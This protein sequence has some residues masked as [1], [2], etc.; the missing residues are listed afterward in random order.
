MQ[1]RMLEL[2]LRGGYRMWWSTITPII[3]GHLSVFSVPEF[4]RVI[5][6]PWHPAEAM[7]GHWDL[8]SI[9]NLARPHPL[10]E[11]DQLTR[12][13]HIA[14][15][16][17]GVALISLQLDDDK[18]TGWLCVELFLSDTEPAQNGRSVCQ[19]WAHILRSSKDD[20]RQEAVLRLKFGELTPEEIAGFR[21]QKKLVTSDLELEVRP[22]R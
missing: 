9:D 14:A 19:D 22:R 1:R 21:G 6:F 8:W 5:D 16:T 2:R 15:R 7:G 11:V 17:L 12:E 3:A 18:R 13:V 4:F 10:K 20:E